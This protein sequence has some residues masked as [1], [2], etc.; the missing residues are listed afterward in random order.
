MG[1]E[2]WGAGQRA[3]RSAVGAVPS[4]GARSCPPSL[5]LAAAL[6]ALAA[7]A[8]RAQMEPQG[9]AVPQAPGQQPRPEREG[10]D[11]PAP[12]APAF[13]LP[14]A[15]ET[16]AP[17][18]PPTVEPEVEALFGAEGDSFAG[19][20]ILAGFGARV[21]AGL[22][23]VWDDN[24][25]GG[26]TRAGGSEF[27]ITP[28]A[29]LSLGRPLGR[30]A[31]YLNANVGWDFHSRNPEFDRERIG[32]GGGLQWRL[33]ARCAGSVDLGYSRQQAQLELFD[34]RAPSTQE[35]F[36][37]SIAGRCSAP[38]RF[39][40][41]LGANTGR[42]D[43]EG[44]RREFADS[45]S[46]GVNGGLAY[47]IGARGQIG[48]FASHGE[49]RFPNQRLP[50]GEAVVSDFTSV[51]GSLGYRLSP[52]L[53]LSGTL[54]W[55]TAGSNSPFRPDFDGVTWSVSAGYSGPRIGA[56]ISTGRSVSGGDG[57]FANFAI[58]ESV[59]AVLTYRSSSRLSFS[60]GYGRS[61]RD[62]RTGPEVPPEFRGV[63]AT[64][65]R[66]FARANM[67]LL[68][69]LSASLA[70]NHTDRSASRVG[71]AYDNWTV[72]ARLRASF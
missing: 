69:F 3:E 36:G 35:R 53:S 11:A 72:I 4:A 29:R 20:N 13:P 26:R 48:A 71:F 42:F 56:R 57:S 41:S 62:N 7:E 19:L 31:L 54:G 44:G 64:T 67:S 2:G 18:A 52:F 58:T 43:Y 23:L 63:D 5:L 66:L 21:S 9:P 70:V 12:A 49:S 24:F 6:A 10:Q 47:P 15:E 28:T 16:P 37:A 27:R 30:Q 34:E 51:G 33:G 22:D 40:T 25:R 60:A 59:D 55:S 38:G 68:R 45:R 17:A 1:Q 8:A 39:I 61:E 50:D 32:V 65:E 14:G 46:W